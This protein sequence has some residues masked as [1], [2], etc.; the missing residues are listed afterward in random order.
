[1]AKGK[2]SKEFEQ[3]GYSSEAEPGQTDMGASK[4]NYGEQRFGM[5]VNDEEPL[6]EPHLSHPRCVS[7]L[8]DREV[9]LAMQHLAHFRPH[10][11][12]AR[13]AN[14]RWC[15]EDF[16][17]PGNFASTLARTFAATGFP[18]ERASAFAA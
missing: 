1:M 18:L 2:G 6:R 12:F 16:P 14:H 15:S 11:D 5:G 10:D 3:S 8:L 7:R 4:I 9:D 17:M 13:R